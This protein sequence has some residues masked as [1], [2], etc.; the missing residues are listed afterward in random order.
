[1][2]AYIIPLQINVLA[3]KPER[4]GQQYTTESFK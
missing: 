4:V 3:D 1:M 2:N